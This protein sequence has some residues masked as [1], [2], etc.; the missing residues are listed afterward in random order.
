MSR[1]FFALYIVFA[2]VATYTAS[3]PAYADVTSTHYRIENPTI[4]PGGTGSSASYKLSG[5]AGETAHNGGSASSYR[6]QL[7]FFSFPVVTAPVLSV[8]VGNAN[9][10]ADLSWSAAIPYL[11]YTVSAYKVGYATASGGP[12]T[13]ISVGNVLAYDVGSLVNGTPYYFIVTALDNASITIATSSEVTATPVAPSLTFVIDSGTQ[14]LPNL[15]PGT[16]TS[17]SSILSIK[18]NNPTGFVTTLARSNVNNTLLLNTDSS[19]AIP[20]KTDW[21]A[22]PAT[23]TNGSASA[24]TTQPLTLQFR[25]WKAMTDSANYSTNWWGADD[26]T[27][28]ALFAGIPSTTQAISNRSV[29]A[30]S[31]TTTR[32]LYDLNVPNSQK[33]GTYSGDVVYTVTVNP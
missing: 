19:V 13:Y 2:L 3:V 27:S 26:T 11:G 8:Q 10:R 5:T 12:Y 30:V 18:T 6:L 28:G 14:A 17:T 25:L 15:T 29:S 33:N 16:L 31:T 1:L 21:T 23:T 24:S 7:G 9:G 22:P 32:V 20:D 4:S